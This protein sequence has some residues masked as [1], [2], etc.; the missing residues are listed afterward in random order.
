[1]SPYRSIFSCVD[2]SSTCCQRSET[3]PATY[4]SACRFPHDT[5][6]A[7]C[8]RWTLPAKEC[9]ENTPE[10]LFIRTASVYHPRLAALLLCPNPPRCS[11]AKVTNSNPL[12]ALSHTE[13]TAA[14][15]AGFSALLIQVLPL[16][17]SVLRV[18]TAGCGLYG[19]GEDARV[20]RWLQ[21]H[22]SALYELQLGQGRVRFGS[23]AA[24]QLLC[25]PTHGL[26][27]GER[28][29][30]CPGCLATLR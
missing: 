24:T 27:R 16:P 19:E 17:C 21:D 7:P 4:P 9:R 11:L 15:A 22:V 18:S 10:P 28:G 29:C 13:H 25:A 12:H 30:K 5:P 1:M 6:Q 20:G 26:C 2:S 8:E 3:W 23:L 14:E